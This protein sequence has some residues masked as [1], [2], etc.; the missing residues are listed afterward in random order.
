[1]SVVP[2]VAGERSE[3]KP[4]GS[5]AVA[6]GQHRPLPERAVR[7]LPRVAAETRRVR[8][9]RRPEEARAEIL[10]S[11]GRLLRERPLHALTVEEIMK[12]TTLSRKS[13]YV[14]F[15]DRYELLEQLFGDVRRRLDAANRLFLAGGDL[16]A[17]GRAAMIAVAEVARE[18]GAPMRALFEASAHDERAERLWRQF[19]EPAVAAFAM[20][21][22]QE[23][24]AGRI[25]PLRDVRGVARALVGMDLF[26]LFDQVIGNESADIAALVD[27]L[28]EVWAGVLRPPEP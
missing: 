23:V 28:T 2:I 15:S 11:A 13:F 18:A 26:I 6:G 9:R 10:A 5:R 3:R 20:K 22:A 21:L 17:D 14:Y 4:F 19:N 12:G 7:N 27:N 24:E 25:A 16:L 8:R 1:M